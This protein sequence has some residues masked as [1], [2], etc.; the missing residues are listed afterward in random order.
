[1]MAMLSAA[2]LLLGSAVAAPTPG[3]VQVYIMMGQSNML[4]E[5]RIGTLVTDTQHL[6]P[7]PEETLANDTPLPEAAALADGTQQQQ[8]A[9]G[10]A[11]SDTTAWWTG[12]SFRA[13]RHG[14]PTKNGSRVD[15]ASEADCCAACASQGHEYWTFQ[16]NFTGKSVP[17]ECWLF[18]PTAA[19]LNVSEFLS[20][21]SAVLNRTSGGMTPLGPKP[22]FKPP[23][24]PPPPPNN[25]LALA[26]Q[27]GKYPYLYDAANKSW[28]VSKT[29]RN[30][31]TMGSGGPTYNGSISTNSW[32]TGGEGH[33]GSIGPELGI[34]A[35]LE[36]H[37]PTAPIMLLKSCI[38][39]RALGWD[40]LP[41]T[42]KSFDWTDPTN[43]SKVWTYAGYGQSPN[44]WEKGTTPVPIT[45]KAG[46]QY[47]GDTKRADTI[48]A[49]LE[50]YY[51]G[52]T[53]YE[54]A[55]F[56]WWQGDRDSRDLALTEHYEANL[57][58]LIKSLRL[59]YKAPDAPFVTASLGQSTLPVSSC[60]GNCGGGILQAMMNVADA[61]KHPEFKGTVGFVDSHPL[62]NTPSSSGSHYGKDANT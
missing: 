30:V 52:A 58:A 35:M 45:W 12:V 18:S 55:G 23:K 33:G 31:F 25:T 60:L 62:E 22:H 32:M 6:A 19:G 44:R 21:A 7:T 47:D 20:E 46:I 61:T 50:T 56:F 48:L 37:S 16:K 53:G 36:Q 17:G 4:G 28:T 11:C 39:N 9:A 24:P 59:R 43:S 15:S 40:L 2:A 13:G 29:V 14:A 5:G 1:M 27:A 3:K 34:G 10:A 26:V 51:P 41:P 57:V 38:G 54:V 42:Q 8:L 49:D